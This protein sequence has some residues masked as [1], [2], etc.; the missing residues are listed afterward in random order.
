MESV[1]LMIISSLCVQA[2]DDPAK[3]Q[4]AD[5]TA[6]LLKTA[7]RGSFSF[8][9]ELKTE[10]DPDD[11]DEEPTVC[12]ISGSTTSGSLAAVE[13]KADDSVHELAL[14]GGKMAG[15]ETW[16]GH[17]VDLV[18]GP[19]ELMSLL[20][21][22]RLGAAVKEA[23]GF[24]ALPDDKVGDEDCSVSE[25]VLPKTAIRSYHDDADVAEEEV[26]SVRRV[27]L[28]IWVRKSDGMVVKFEATVRRLYKDDK[29]RGPG[30]KGMSAVTLLMKDFG[31]AV[32][33]VPPSLEKL[34]KD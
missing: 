25:M 7:K 2:Q 23:T 26:K 9:G 13:I 6:A 5:I 8:T 17:S 27:P 12:A 21:L 32:V 19:S 15:R 3:V 4:S 20:D 10:V 22:E 1:L 11:A 33:A 31:T 16:K 18:N 24:K 29:Q 28:R 30:T 34:L 14:K